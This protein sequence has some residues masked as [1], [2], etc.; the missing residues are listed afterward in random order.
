MHFLTCFCSDSWCMHVCVCEPIYVH[1]A[2]T[3]IF[4]AIFCHLLVPFSRRLLSPAITRTRNDAR[5]MISSVSDVNYSWTLIV[6]CNYTVSFCAF[7]ECDIRG[8]YLREG[9]SAVYKCTWWNS[10]T[11]SAAANWKKPSSLCKKTAWTFVFLKR[12]KKYRIT[13][14]RIIER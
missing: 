5:V 14:L 2:K 8:D 12:K 1:C 6:W 3:T 4:E 13:M 10:S 9:V 7:W 11:T